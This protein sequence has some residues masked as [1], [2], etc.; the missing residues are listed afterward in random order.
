MAWFGAHREANVENCHGREVFH[1][2]HLIA[3]TPQGTIFQCAFCLL[4][5]NLFQ[6]QRSYLAQEQSLDPEAISLEDLFYDAC[7]N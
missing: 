5:Y 1:L 4:L 2:Q 6:V 7:G 3:S